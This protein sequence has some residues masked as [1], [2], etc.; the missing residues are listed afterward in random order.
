MAARARG[1]IAA[2]VAASLLL[3]V[4]LMLRRA[5][6]A[7]QGSRLG[8]AAVR[9]AAGAPRPRQRASGCSRIHGDGR[10]RVTKCAAAFVCVCGTVYA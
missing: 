6:G 4:Q 10:A 2:I 7:G 9:G 1:S 3:Q 8:E 5:L